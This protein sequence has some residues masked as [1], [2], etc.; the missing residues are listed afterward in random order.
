MNLGTCKQNSWIFV[1]EVWY[2]AFT[3]SIERGAGDKPEIKIRR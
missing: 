2:N 1:V 3:Q